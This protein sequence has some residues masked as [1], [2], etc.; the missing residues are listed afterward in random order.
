MTTPKSGFSWDGKNI[1]FRAG[2]VLL[3]LSAT[4][5]ARPIWAL[6]GLNF[7]DSPSSN[8]LEIQKK[9][10]RMEMKLDGFDTKLNAFSRLQNDFFRLNNRLS[11]FEIDF[12]K[13]RIAH[14]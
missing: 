6:A 4:P 1:S 9:V 14:P 10:E 2:L 12:T 11:G 13:Y 7:P 8:L 3:V 5:L